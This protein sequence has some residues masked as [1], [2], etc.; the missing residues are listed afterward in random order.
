MAEAVDAF[1]FDLLGALA[2]VLHLTG[3]EILVQA[4][5]RAHLEHK[6]LPAPC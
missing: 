6:S 3:T 4:A 5:P 1:G 2:D